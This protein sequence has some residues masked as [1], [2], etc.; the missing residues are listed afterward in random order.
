[1]LTHV[2]FEEGRPESRELAELFGT[3]LLLGEPAGDD[4]G[5]EWV[6]RRF[7]GKFRV[8]AA[9]AGVPTITPELAHNKQLVEPAIETGLAG[10][11]NVLAGLDMLERE[12]AATDPTVARNH[13]G[14]VAAA[15]SGLFRANPELELGQRV[16]AGRHLGTLYD[17]TSYEV[18]QEAVADRD[19]L[20]YSIAREATVTAGAAIANVAVVRE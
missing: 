7:D 13:L 1:M 16:R 10:L 9:D 17:P 5:E 18:L 3:E 6:R 2:V 20:L 19:G 4:A 11:E 8:A 12:P 15:D 14:R